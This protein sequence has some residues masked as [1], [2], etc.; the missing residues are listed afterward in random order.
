MYHRPQQFYEAS[1]GLAHLGKFFRLRKV[2]LQSIPLLVGCLFL[3]T[4]CQ[5]PDSGAA[6]ARTPDDTPVVLELFTSQGCSSCPPADALLSQ[7]RAEKTIH[8][9]EV[10]VLSHHVDYWNRLGWTDP[11]SRPEA[12]DRQEYY[13]NKL[14]ARGL[15]TP[16]II[17]DGRQEMVGH[18]E[19]KIRKAIAESKT[20]PDTIPVTLQIQVDWKETNT[21]QIT[22]ITS[23]ELK[24]DELLYLLLAEDELNNSVPRGENANRTLSHDGVV[25]WMK[26]L[27]RS[28][29]KPTVYKH[30]ESGSMQANQNLRFVALVQSKDAS[31]SGAAQ[32]E[33]RPD[34][35]R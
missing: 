13:A 23:R 31:I 16:Q 11:Y 18:N 15:Y 29:L 3:L 6:D 22:V 24:E 8:G 19:S 33:I 21:M 17:V 28:D 20:V 2:S 26:P 7:F 9:R 1:G 25:H 12:S 35:I 34:A 10:I 30:F 4:G 32:K 14:K 5:G 27:K